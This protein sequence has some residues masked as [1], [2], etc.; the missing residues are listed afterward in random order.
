MVKGPYPS[1]ETHLEQR[2]DPISWPT[3]K[4]WPIF[5]FLP[6]LLFLILSRCNSN[7]QEPD[8]LSPKSSGL[9]QISLFLLRFRTF[10][11]ARHELDALEVPTVIFIPISLFFFF[12]SI[13]IR[14]GTNWYTSQLAILIY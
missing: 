1:T 4:I 2:K 10:K 12:I 5:P 9:P 13:S 8:E 7:K 11:R 3:S 14:N 6:L